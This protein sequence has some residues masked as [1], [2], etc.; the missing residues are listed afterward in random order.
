MQV[1][2]KN[3]YRVFSEITGV[4]L[5]EDPDAAL[6]WRNAVLIMVE[7]MLKGKFTG[8]KFS[9]YT[10]NDQLDYKRSRG[11]I[12]GSDKN[13]IIAEYAEKFENILRQCL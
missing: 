11:I 7:G 1:T 4:D 13:E 2:C 3:N 10:I 9:D 5:V 12:N 6:D 8:K